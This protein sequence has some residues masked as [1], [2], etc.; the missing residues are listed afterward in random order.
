MMTERK[1]LDAVILDAGGTLLRLDFEWMVDRLHDLGFT[2]TVDVLRRAEVTGRRRYDASSGETTPPGER[3][4]PLGSAGDI[5]EYFGGLLEAAGVTGETLERMAVA[6]R[7]RESEAIGNWGRAAEGAA[8]AVAALRRLGVR[9]AV[10]SNSDGRAEAHL[11]HSGVGD[12]LEFVVD[13]QVVGVEKPDPEIFRIA[14]RRLGVD[15]ARALY[16]GDIRSVDER[17]S[18]AAGME[19]VLIDPYGDYAGETTPSIRSIAE[20]PAWVSARYDISHISDTR[21]HAEN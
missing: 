11:E 8:R 14:L 19:F 6:V 2:T 3:N 17:G 15:A 13:S 18:Q 7:E 1:P 9:L 4:V 20:L 16:V 12:H 21:T 5:R 10:V